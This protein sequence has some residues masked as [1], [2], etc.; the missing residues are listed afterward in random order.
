LERVQVVN[1]TP[2]QLAFVRLLQ[3][4][5]HQSDYVAEWRHLFQG[6][7]IRAV[8]NKG[9][10]ATLQRDKAQS[11]VDMGLMRPDVGGTFYLTDLG[12]GI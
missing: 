8:T 12:R 1:L 10:K 9:R 4:S 2:D 7:M 3:L 11:L 6:A 5:I